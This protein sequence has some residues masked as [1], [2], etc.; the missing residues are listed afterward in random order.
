MKRLI[1]LLIPVLFLAACATSP[2]TKAYTE[3]DSSGK[4]NTVYAPAP[5][6][7]NAVAIGSEVNR[8]VPA[9]PASPFIDYGLGA[10]ATV[11]GLIAAFQN[12]RARAQTAAAD[13]LAAHVVKSGTQTAALQVASGTSAYS[14]VA[15]H[16]D[17]NTVT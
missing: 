10:L 6:L 7:T 2:L 15:Q 3:V 1:A 12:K 9:N 4:T 11:A 17:N 13:L 16:I 8:T 14:D 5:W